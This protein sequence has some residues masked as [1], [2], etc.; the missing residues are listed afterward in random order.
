MRFGSIRSQPCRGLQSSFSQRKP[1]GSMIRPRYRI[2]IFVGTGELSVSVEKR[3]IALHRFIQKFNCLPL[4]L[5]L[6]HAETCRQEK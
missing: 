6:R 1:G 4:V 5:I 3:G 2:K